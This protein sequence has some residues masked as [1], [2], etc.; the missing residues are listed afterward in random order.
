MSEER[1][2]LDREMRAVEETLRDMH[3][4]V[5]EALAGAINGFKD[6]DQATLKRIVSGDAAL[7]EMQHRVEALCFEILAT[8]QPVA[9]DLRRVMTFSHIAEELER[10]GDHAAAIAEIAL[11]NTTSD[12]ARFVAKIETIATRCRGMVDQAIRAYQDRDE[13]LARAVGEADNEVDQLQEE[14]VEL[15]I[16]SMC[17]STE[18][19]RRGSHLLWIEHN[20]ERVADR[21]TN[22]A[23]RVIF[24]VSGKTVDLN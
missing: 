3:S 22:I 7:N 24:M 13:G 12:D 21:A 19:A 20:L 18:A 4:L 11:A 2:I 5:A 14:F 16:P 6:G 10:I 17:G 9:G 15:V 23:E 8:Q 1:R